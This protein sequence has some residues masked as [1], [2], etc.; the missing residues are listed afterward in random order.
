MTVSETWLAK[1][2]DRLRKTFF[3]SLGS[4]AHGSL[5]QK[6]LKP[7]FLAEVDRLRRLMEAF[8]EQVQAAIAGKIQQTQVE[9]TNA[10]FPRVRA[11]PPAD[12][13]RRTATGRL[14][15]DLLRQRLKDAIAT[16]FGR[17]HE[18]Y[19]PRL[20]VVFKGVNYDTIV[21]DSHFREKITEYFGEVEAQQL[22]SEYDASRART[23]PS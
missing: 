16:A 21:S 6:R 22:L 15:D 10:L 2:A 20:T 18:S 3:I 13:L 19:T 14:D 7:E 9:L 1:E 5:I 23:S 4:S 8:A 12:W 17:A 11:A